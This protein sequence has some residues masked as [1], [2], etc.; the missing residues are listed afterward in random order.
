MMHD[1]V[2]DCSTVTISSDAMHLTY[3]SC[4]S[5]FDQISHATYD[6]LTIYVKQNTFHIRMTYFVL[7]SRATLQ[8]MHNLQM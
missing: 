4:V 3:R 5:T 6:M 2:D 1:I 8:N 7:L